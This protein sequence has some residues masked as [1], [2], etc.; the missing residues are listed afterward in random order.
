[1]IVY[2]TELA[3]ALGLV[4]TILLSALFTRKDH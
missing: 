2:H 4:A 1:M 3:I